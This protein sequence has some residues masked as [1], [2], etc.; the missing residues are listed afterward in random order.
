MEAGL[1]LSQSSLC[2]TAVNANPS[3]HCLLPA[4]SPPCSVSSLL[5]L[6]HPRFIWR[7]VL[8]INGVAALELLTDATD[9]ARSFPLYRAIWRDAQ[10]Y[11]ALSALLNAPGLTDLLTKALTQRFYDFLKSSPAP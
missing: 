6:Q 10:V 8:C 3:V 7:A 2:V 9:M 1:P 11:A 4:L 5:L